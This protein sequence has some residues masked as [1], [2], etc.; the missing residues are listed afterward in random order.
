MQRQLLFRLFLATSPLLV[1]CSDTVEFYDFDGDGTLDLE[2]RQ[3]GTRSPA[4]AA[5][6]C[7]WFWGAMPGQPL[8]RSG[9]SA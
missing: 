1:G 6:A 5:F 8:A 9:M 7:V 4:H 2:W 3:V